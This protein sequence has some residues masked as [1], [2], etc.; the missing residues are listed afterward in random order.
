[1]TQPKPHEAVELLIARMDSYPEEFTDDDRWDD[2]LDK[3]REYF[4]PPDEKAYALA[5]SKLMLKKFHDALMAE[6][7]H[8][9]SE[10]Q[11]RV[12]IA[13]GYMHM[14]GTGTTWSQN[15]YPQNTALGLGNGLTVGN[16]ACLLQNTMQSSQNIRRRVSLETWVTGILKGLK[17]RII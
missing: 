2:L 11:P 7:L 15:T 4:T 16:S 17:C 13:Q 6:L 12:T 8:P 9:A 14:S 10:E 3:Y 1:M 5:Y